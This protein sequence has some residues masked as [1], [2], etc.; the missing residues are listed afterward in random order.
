MKYTINILFFLFSFIVTSQNQS[1]FWYFGNNAGLDFSSGSPTAIFNGQ[2]TFPTG[3]SHNEGTSCISDSS[4]SLLFY[5]DGVTVW[6]KN[7]LIML[8]GSNLLGNFSSTQSS[9]IVPSP[10]NPDRYFYVFTVSSLMGAVV[11][12]NPEDGLNYSIIDMCLDSN[13]GGVIDTAKNKKLMDTVAEKIAVTRH[14]NGIDYWI[15]THKFYS[16]DFYAFK[17]TSNGITDTIITAIGSSHTGSTLGVQGQLKFSPNGS[18]VAIAASNGLNL[19]ELFDFDNSTGILSN[20]KPLLKPNNDRASIYGVEF[21]PDNS[22]LYASG[23]T[24]FGVLNPFLVQYDLNAA[25]GTLS[26]IN[27][28]IYEV[29]RITG[30]CILSGRGL[31]LGIDNKIYWVSIN[32]SNPN[33]TLASINN[34]NVLGAG[35]N[36]QDQAVSLGGRI[37]SFTLPS[38]I[39]GIDYSNKMINCDI[40]E[41]PVLEEVTLKLP[42]VFTPNNDGINDFFIPVELIGINDFEIT[43]YNRWGNLVYESV[44]KLYWDGK[45]KGKDCSEGVYFWVIRTNEEV[46]IKKGSVSIF[47]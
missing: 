24:S 39:A 28:S 47:R 26:A 19:L 25:G 12:S 18:K 38:F 35:C 5:T 3:Q 27:S 36:Y 30:P 42:N 16:N 2:I 20:F 33:G 15:L 6:N 11:N 46:K 8:N 45:Y 22:K 41:I 4:G 21:S 44:N 43:I 37:G 29:Y 31:Q 13:L 17:L 34:P 14:S 23:I 1:N 7:H 32:I 9:I 40:N 10:N